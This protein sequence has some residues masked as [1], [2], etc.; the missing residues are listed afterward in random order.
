MTLEAQQMVL[1]TLLDL[2]DLEP[3]DRGLFRSTA[4]FDGPP[5]IYGGQIAAQALHAAGRTVAPERVPH[6][7]HCYYLRS[8]ATSRP[9]MF[10]VDEDRDGRSYS[11]RRVTAVQDGAV[12]FT[13]SA[14]FATSTASAPDHEFVPA[15][16]V[17]GPEGLPRFD[18]EFL[19]SLDIR[20]PPQRRPLPYPSLFWVRGALD[21]PDTPLMQAC[22][23]TYLSDAS[24]GLVEAPE[25][26]D[27]A[28][29]SIDHAVWFHRPFR[30]DQWHVVDFASVAISRGRGF[31]SGG[32]WRADGTLT[33]SVTQEALF[34]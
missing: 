7:L 14:S 6:S 30:F 4:V 2:L 32:V 31:Y 13:L 9:V 34:R 1:P 17:P 18:F 15:P 10:R 3:V 26:E 11:A 8:G 22:A 5:R 33:A 25:G 29:P 28:G 12:I 27:R 16:D 21:I 24:T 19:T 23:L 20:V